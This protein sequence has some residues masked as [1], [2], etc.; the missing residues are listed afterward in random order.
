MIIDGKVY[1]NLEGQVEY[2]TEYLQSNAVAAEL[3]IKVIGTEENVSDIPAGEYNYGDAYMIGTEVPYTLYIWTRA[4]GNH[5]EDFWFEVGKFPM[6]G[7]QGEIGIGIDDVISKALGNWASITSVVDGNDTAI[8]M[9]GTE[10]TTTSDNTTYTSDETVDLPFTTDGQVK[11]DAYDNKIRVR[12]NE[13]LPSTYVHQRNGNG[14][15]FPYVYGT[16]AVSSSKVDGLVPCPIK[17]RED[18]VVMA[19]GNNTTYWSDTY[20]TI[21][22]K[23]NIVGESSRPA[24]ADA[25]SCTENLIFG[26][27]NTV[28]LAVQDS[29]TF[30]Y[31]NI[32]GANQAFTAGYKNENYG[33]ESIV[34]GG[35]NFLDGTTTVDTTPDP[36][37][38]GYDGRS[39]TT[40]YM[41]VF[42]N[43]NSIQHTNTSSLIGGYNNKVNNNS[44][45]NF[46]IGANHNL[47][48]YNACVNT[49]DYGNTTGDYVEDSTMIG[50]G[51]HIYGGASGNVVY[52][53]NILGNNCSNRSSGTNYKKVSMIGEGLI[54][55]RDDQIVMGRYNAAN[56][57]DTFQLGNGTADDY[58]DNLFTISN[59]PLDGPM[60]TLGNVSL[61]AS[62]ITA[63]KAL[64]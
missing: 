42:G 24:P 34:I 16:N 58:R 63:L 62:Q 32:A 47:G 44:K 4:N 59:D 38:G 22:G 54:A 55:S 14:S 19:R 29:S 28:N 9:V 10:S 15:G 1:R 64:I 40:K 5:P 45:W 36:D 30:G 49:L 48:K 53:V 8:T 50:Y 2:L 43:K 61:T 25:Y 3:G 18:N 12:L 11:I 21:L 33:S 6:P 52:A 56:P 17:L 60:I 13:T 20:N 35:Q 51:N 7:P 26:G 46:V 23:E 31:R 27:K 39:S 57:Y 37:T 41:A